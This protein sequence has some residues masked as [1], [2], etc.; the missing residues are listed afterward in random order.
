[1]LWPATVSAQTPEIPVEVE[2][3]PGWRTDSGTHMAAFRIRLGDGWKTYWRAPGDAGI[4][5]QFQ[6]T[7]TNNITAS[8]VRWPTPEVFTL[9]GL[10]S[11]GY[12]DEV[13]I[14]IEFQT[15]NAR[16]AHVEG[17]LE[18]GVC[19]EICIPFSA[20]FAADLGTDSRRDPRIMAALLDG[21]WSAVKARVSKVTCTLAPID[22]GLSVQ[23]AI[24]LPQDGASEFVVIEAS[25][26]TIWVTEADSERRGAVLYSS[27]ELYPAEVGPMA[28]D[29]SALRMTI[30]TG[31]H[32]VDIRGCDAG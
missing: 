5:P 10:R 12:H 23:T 24:T 21:P 1:M 9:S 29:R 19:E 26:P 17:I 32:A 31:N 14:P 27:A 20:P 28:L 6:W 4:P 16:D 3:L 30:L 8:A 18:I 25:D 15:E 13:I 7:V 11:I 2:F 22:G